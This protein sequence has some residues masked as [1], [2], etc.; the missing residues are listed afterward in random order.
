M[1]RTSITIEAIDAISSTGKPADF[2]KIRDDIV[3]IMKPLSPQMRDRVARKLQRQ[4]QAEMDKQQTVLKAT[5]SHKADLQARIAAL[6]ELRAWNP[7]LVLERNDCS[8]LHKVKEANAAG[9]VISGGE[10]HHVAEVSLPLLA[11][12]H[13]FVVKH[14]WAA[15]LEGAETGTDDFQLPYERCAFEFRIGGRTVIVAFGTVGDDMRFTSFIEAGDFWY[16][17]REMTEP[18]AYAYSQVR[19]ICIALDAEV[20]TH[21]VV[22]A[23]HK[24]NEKRAR[25][26][27]LPLLDFHVVDLSR[28]HRVSNGSNHPGAGTRK[29][30]HFRRGHWRHYETSKTW[31][32][33]CLVG[34]PD[35]GFIQK[36]YIL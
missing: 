29:R 10:D 32:K 22:R 5:E 23:P 30:L 14:D 3:Q 12:E 18:V 28:R 27:K 8:R 2:E 34:D 15:A 13:T 9:R 33:W 11:L 21:S 16:S 7:A 19:G 31:V 36:S 26:G 20:A 1:P 25:Q 6:E 35:L 24:L 4:F 17:A